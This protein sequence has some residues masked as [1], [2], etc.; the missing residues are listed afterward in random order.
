LRRHGRAAAQSLPTIPT[1]NALPDADSEAITC[2]YEMSRKLRGPFYFDETN[3]QKWAAS[4]L[5]YIA[6]FQIGQ[7]TLSRMIEV[8][9]MQLARLLD[10]HRIAEYDGLNFIETQLRKKAFWL[11]FYGYV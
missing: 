8:E 5:L 1:V 2:C 6:F 4:H 7:Q 9:A 11:M 10:I 3:L